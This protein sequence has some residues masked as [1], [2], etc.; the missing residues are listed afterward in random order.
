MSMENPEHT[1]GPW[2]ARA[3]CVTNDGTQDEMAGLG[4]NIEGPPEPTRG[5]FFKAA[6]AY[7]AAA[8]PEMYKALKAMVD[9]FGPLED[10]HLVHKTA[11][12]AT[13]KA[14][15]AIAKAEGKTTEEAELNVRL[16][17]ALPTLL[18]IVELFADCYPAQIEPLQGRARWIIAKVRGEATV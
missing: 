7:L 18:E 15:A 16:T 9:H 17:A 14:K 8:S 2:K 5:Q 1:A 3:R 12:L 4:W 11:R 13:K 10:N 6:D